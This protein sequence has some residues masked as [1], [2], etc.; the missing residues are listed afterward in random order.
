M[1]VS[2][3]A[4]KRGAGGALGG[5]S[6]SASPLTCFLVSLV[7]GGR[8]ALLARRRLW[9]VAPAFCSLLRSEWKSPT[10]LV[11]PTLYLPESGEHKKSKQSQGVQALGRIRAAELTGKTRVHLF[12]L[13]LNPSLDTTTRTT[14]RTLQTHSPKNTICAEALLSMVLLKG[15]VAKLPKGP[16]SLL[17]LQG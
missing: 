2:W 9:V 7:R 11:H 16:D 4:V 17:I 6:G 15:S 10:R 12:I 3:V 5:A 14:V 1:G 13:I 8:L